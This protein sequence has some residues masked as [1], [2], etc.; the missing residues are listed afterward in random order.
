MGT[1][2]EIREYLQNGLSPQVLVQK[3]NYKKSTVYKV[4]HTLRAFNAMIKKPDW[5]IENIHFDRPN[6]RYLPGESFIVN[7][8]FT[9]TSERH[10][11]IANI[12]AHMEWM[13]ADSWYSMNIND[14]LKSRE[15]RSVSLCIPIPNNIALG[16]YE[17]MFGVE[18]QHLPVQSY[19]DQM[20][21]TLWSEPY[22]LDIK[23]NLTAEKIF[24]SHSLDDIYLVREIEKQFDKFGIEV[25]IGE[26]QRRP[27][28]DIEEKFKQM[29]NDCT[30]FV[31]LLTKSALMSRWVIMETN[32]AF[33][34]NKLCIPLKDE[35]VSL[36]TKLEW[37]P[38]SKESSPIAVWQTI[39]TAIADS[40]TNRQNLLSSPIVAAL[41]IAILGFLIGWSLRGES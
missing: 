27:G 31:A 7:F 4:Y 40:R 20:L 37:I 11:F 28:Y 14:I 13:T 33:S 8:D 29:V 1:E 25:M 38:F 30:I 21:V 34:I 24:L 10:I 22:I 16:E 32:Y 35:S 6:P 15:R 2:D 39:M 12:G 23:H 19:R 5:S 26:D 17:M 41:G 36:E 18:C 9:N 3:Y